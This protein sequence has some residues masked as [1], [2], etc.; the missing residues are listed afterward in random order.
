MD[1]SYKKTLYQHPSGFRLS[2][3][4]GPGASDSTLGFLHY[5]TQF[6]LIYFICGTGSLKVEGR[7]YHIKQGDL[8]LLSPTELYH[9]TVDDTEYHERIVIHFN[10]SVLT[11]FP[12]DANAVL[13]PLI[14]RPKG[15]GNHIPR[16]AVESTGMAAC[17]TDLLRLVPDC[18]P[19]STV[20]SQCRL[21]E[22]LILTAQLLQTGASALSPST[23]QENPLVS[24]ILDYLN[25]HFREE[26][27][28]SS[29]AA[30][31]HLTSSYLS[32]LFKEHTGMSMWN[33]V[34]LRRL[35]A[36]N[37]LIQKEQSVEQACYQVGFR[38]Y[39]NFFRLYTKHTGLT[40]SQYKKQLSDR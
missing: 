35:R 8:I 17:L 16:S 18:S 38:N 21:A 32:H 28:I 2:H 7:H 29:V 20:L 27:T 30:E 39:S 24:Q 13:A 34:V 15:T 31:F 36:F 6:M 26:F 19:S 23:G 22:L 14:S 33:Y 5:T 25:N 3:T 9:C 12:C 11:V 40:P 1:S 37:D 4:A 10:L